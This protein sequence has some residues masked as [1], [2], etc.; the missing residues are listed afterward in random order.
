MRGVPFNPMYTQGWSRVGC[1]GCPL[2]GNQKKELDGFPKYKAAYFRAVQ[3]HYEHRR[4][5]GLPEKEG[6]PTPESYFDWWL[7]GFDGGEDAG[8][9]LWDE[10]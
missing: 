1:I 5:T 8:V 7:G 10:A 6:F 4:A 2:S 9:D 3:R